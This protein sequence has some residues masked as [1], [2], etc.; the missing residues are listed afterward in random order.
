MKPFA[1]Q[2]PGPNPKTSA[3]GGNSSPRERSQRS[4]T[5]FT[6]HSWAH[7]GKHDSSPVHQASDRLPISDIFPR[8]IGFS[9]PPACP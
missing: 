9:H 2:E 6:S 8:L 7:R 4:I 3:K 1:P 5:H